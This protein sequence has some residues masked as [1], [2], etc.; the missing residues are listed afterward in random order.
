M[1]KILIPF[2]NAIDP[3]SGG[4][5][6]VY[7]NLVPS[8]IK[9][10]YEVY[11]TYHIRSQYDKASVYTDVFYLGEKTRNNN[12]IKNEWLQIIKQKNINIVICPFV[13]SL[14]YDF[15]SQ[16]KELQ[17]YF[18]IH[19]VPSVYCYPSYSKVPACLRHTFVDDFLKWLRF[20]VFFR[21]SFDRIN[22]NGMKIILLSDR[23]KED[24][25]SFF[26]IDDDN[27]KA[28]PNPIV[29]DENFDFKRTHKDKTILYVGRIT[30]KQKRFQ[31]LLNIWGKLQDILPEYN[32]EVVGGGPEKEYYEEKAREMNLKRV[33]FHGF[34]SPEEFYIKAQALCMVSNYEGFGMVLVEAMQYGCVPFAFDSFAALPD[35]ID[36]G[37]NGY[38]ITPFNEEIYVQRIVDFIKKAREEKEK[39]YNASMSKA[40]LFSVE[41]IAKEW[42]RLFDNYKL[43]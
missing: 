2:L 27:L 22:K 14:Y 24:F 23:F 19:N 34:Q 33:V 16:Q 9:M 29:R 31:S 32:L 40:K 18:H 41:N 12:E 28:I 4:V 13:N 38:R 36:D 37:I 15:F 11:A 3:T 25:K 20:T 6:R 35:I 5:E 21:K 17:V 42:I 8:F 39:I 26:S 10:G 43:A 7:H 1:K 30:T